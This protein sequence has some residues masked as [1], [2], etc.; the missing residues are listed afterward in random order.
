[1][2]AAR[3]IFKLDILYKRTLVEVWMDRQY[4]KG[5]ATGQNGKNAKNM[6]DSKGKLQAMEAKSTRFVEH[7]LQFLTELTCERDYEITK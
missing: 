7:F 4:A 2:G 6:E 3:A 5:D 1:M